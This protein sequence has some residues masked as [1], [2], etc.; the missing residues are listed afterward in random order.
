MSTVAP[1]VTAVDVLEIEGFRLFDGLF[2][3]SSLFLP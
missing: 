1:E 2:N 3:A